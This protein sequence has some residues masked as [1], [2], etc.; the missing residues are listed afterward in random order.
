[1]KS[2]IEKIENTIIAIEDFPVQGVTF[3]DVT[4]LFKHPE[5]VSAIIDS[6]AE[7]LKDKKIDAIVGVESRGYLFGVPLA[8]KMNVPFIL[9]RKPNKLPRPTYKQQF[10]LEYGC[11][12]L[13]VHIGDIEP[14]MNVCIIDDLLATGGTIGAVEKLVKKSNA[15][16][17]CALFLIELEKLH[18]FK[19]IESPI[20]SLIKY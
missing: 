9:V 12:T 18:G 5:L 7:Y 20:F 3:R 1:M 13:E 11:S 8:L 15:N 16:T 17:I 4:P 6:F 2:L 14:N 10:D 19:K